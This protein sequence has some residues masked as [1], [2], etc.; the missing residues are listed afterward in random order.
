MGMDKKT[1]IGEIDDVLSE[2]YPE[3]KIN[4][5]KILRSEQKQRGR[6]FLNSTKLYL[7]MSG[8]IGGFKE[9]IHMIRFQKDNRD[10]EVQDALNTM[11]RLGSFLTSEER[12]I[13]LTPDASLTRLCTNLMH[14][15]TSLSGH[16]TT[17]QLERL[18]DGL[19]NLEKVFKGVCTTMAE[20]MARAASRVSEIRPSSRE[21]QTAV[22][23]SGGNVQ[24]AAS[25]APGSFRP[26][27]P[28]G[29]DILKNLS[30][31][32]GRENKTPVTPSDNVMVYDGSGDPGSKNGTRTLWWVE[33]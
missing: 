14:Q 1:E 28:H 25:S 27:T 5:Y 23:E 18:E 11:A 17:E 2:D 13:G 12:L 24:E 16:C 21:Q 26:S 29:A 22:R 30:Q 7:D 31:V 32:K 10:K 20:D 6:D 8:K 3:K 15:L 19:A 9:R 4:A 33:M